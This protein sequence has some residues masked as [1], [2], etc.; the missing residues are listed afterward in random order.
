MIKLDRPNKPIELTQEVQLTLT[1]KFKETGESVWSKA[2]IKNALV[3][4]SSNKCA[5]CETKLGEESKYLEVEH[6]HHKSLYKEEVVE[7]D[8]LLPSCKRC[9]GCK[10][11]HDTKLEPI[12]N[13]CNAAPNLHISLENNYRFKGKDELGKMSISILNLNDQDKLILKRFQIGNTIIDKLDDFIDKVN[14]VLAD[15][16]ALTIR[17]SR[18][19]NDVERL[20]NLGLKDKE[21]SGTYSTLLIRAGEFKELKE[22]M[23]RAELWEDRHSEL[24]RLLSLNVLREIT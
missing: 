13:P 9:N 24:E 20:L 17:K 4:M 8:N 2:Y 1:E 10:S 11:N 23:I 12:I 21:Y 6:F 14:D 15:V 22:K 16:N 19:K 7:W 18:I 5:F 3:E